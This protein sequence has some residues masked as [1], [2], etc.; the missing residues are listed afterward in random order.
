MDNS[1]DLKPEQ[2]QKLEA[3]FEEHVSIAMQNAE[4]KQ[5]NEE[6]TM[7]QK[8]TEASLADPKTAGEMVVGEQKQGV[9]NLPM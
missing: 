1:E 4:R 6:M 7:K 9:D 5:Y 8:Q 3:Y 2:K